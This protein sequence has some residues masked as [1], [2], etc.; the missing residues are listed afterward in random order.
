MYYTT[1]PTFDSLKVLPRTH[2]K[3]NGEGV[4]CIRSSR[5][6]SAIG[7]TTVQELGQR[8]E[9]SKEAAETNKASF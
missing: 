2:W 7:V 4:D 8:C 6:V 5:E 3:R 9:M 1:G